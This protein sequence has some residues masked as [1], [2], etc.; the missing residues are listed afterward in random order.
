MTLTLSDSDG[1]AVRNPTPDDIDAMLDD[2]DRDEGFVILER[3][4]LEFVQATGG[5]IE[6]REGNCHYRAMIE[7]GDRALVR[8]IFVEYLSGGDSWKTAAQWHDVTHEIGYFHGV[9]YGWIVVAFI[10]L[11]IAYVVFETTR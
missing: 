10:V 2:L 9:P 6:Y 11:M 1:R 3:A 8:R 7:P 5:C 4:P